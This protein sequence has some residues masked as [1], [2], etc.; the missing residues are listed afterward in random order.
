MTAPSNATVRQLDRQYVF[1]SWSAQGG[2]N[3]LVIAGGEGCRLWDYDG[4]TYLDF[5]SQLVNTNIGA[6]H[7]K[8][9]A[10]IKAQADQLTTIAP[11]TANLARG[12]AAKRIVSLAPENFSK[13]FFTNAGADANEN[14]IRMARLFTGRD[15]ILSSYRSYHG[16]TGS[17]IGATGDWRRLPND[18]FRGHIH[19]FTPYLYRSEFHATTEEEECQTA[20]HH[21]RRIIECEGPGTIAAILLETIPGTA[22][23][24]MPPPGYLAGVSALAREFGI[25]LI[26]DEVMAGFGRT[27][28]WFTFDHYGITPDLI[29]F[30]KG[31]NSGYVPAGGVIISDPIAHFFD[32]RVFPGGLTYS[33]HPLAM[34]A[35]VATLD[36]M[37][38]EGIVDNAAQVGETVLAP[39]LRHLAEKYDI[40]GETRGKG[41]F[42]ALELVTD[43]IAKTPMPADKMA[44]LKADLYARG[45]LGFLAENRVHVVPP[46]VVT[47]NEARQ[48]L[49]II[50]DALA[51][52]TATLD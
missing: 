1:H 40:V 49:A 15:K 45:L 13:V 23:I 6:Q 39:G 35:I 43:P 42:H 8:V 17:A 14:A 5:S 44:Q 46:C 11:A 24:L 4:K 48:G 25:L 26:M 21:L 10:A 20:L 3:P 30:A 31:V 28:R 22:G 27:G 38:E 36:A 2:L 19:F 16:N 34:A 33:G 52:L 7:P 50:D 32:D 18:Y 51:A 37:V 29:T 47:A 9:V 12:E 41:V